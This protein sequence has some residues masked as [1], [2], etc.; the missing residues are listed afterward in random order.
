MATPPLVSDTAFPTKTVSEDA[1]H[2]LWSGRSTVLELPDFPPL[3]IFI[4][5]NVSPVGTWVIFKCCQFDSEDEARKAGHLFRDA[6]LIVGAIGRLGVDIG[7]DRQ[8]LSFSKKIH[9]GVWQVSKQ[10]LRAEMHGLMIYEKGTVAIIRMEARGTVSTGLSALQGQLALW[11][12]KLTVLTERQKNCALLLNDSFF[13]ANVES[14]FVLRVSAVEALC[15]PSEPNEHY[16]S[17]VQELQNHLA[18]LNAS[19]DALRSLER[20]FADALRGSTRQ[21]YMRKFRSLLGDTKAKAF[22]N[23]YALR[24]KFVHEGEGR[25]NLSEA[26]GAALELSVGL[27]NAE[28]N[29][30][31]KAH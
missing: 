15:A 21:S 30:K 2:N 23:L 26:A 4:Q 14:Q 1:A 6:L 9:E 16:Q 29:S 24:S 22:D 3:E 27:L 25:G 20:T 17:V 18:T 5:H 31:M 10:E 12:D 11:L 19:E 8:T 28:L 13:T 7:H